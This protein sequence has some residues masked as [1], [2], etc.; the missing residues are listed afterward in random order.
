MKVGELFVALGFDIKGREGLL[1]VE[2]GMK[3]AAAG[4]GKLTLG[5]AAVNAGM[6]ILIGTALRAGVALKNFG[7]Q[8]RLDTTELQRWQHMAAVNDVSGERLTDTI[9]GLQDARAQFALGEPE[10]VGAWSLLGVNPTQ[11]P[12]KVLADLRTRLRSFSDVGIARNLASRVGISADIFQ[13]L[14]ASNEEFERWNRNLAVLPAQTERLRRLDAAWKSLRFAL[15]AV[16]NQFAA[17]FAPVLTVVAKGLEKLAEWLAIITRWLTGTSPIARVAAWAIGIMAVALLGLGVALAVV[18]AALGLLLGL[19]T[20]FSPALI[21][22]GLALAP[23]AIDFLVIAGAVTALILLLDDL[24]TA[25]KGGK[26]YFSWGPTRAVIGALKKVNLHD[27]AGGLLDFVG[28]V[29]D[30]GI[31]GG[32]EGIAA[33]PASAAGRSEVTQNNDIRIFVNGD[34][35]PVRNARF[36]HRNL[37]EEISGAAYQ[38]PVRNW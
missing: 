3:T 12:F 22:V 17:A 4:A 19:L 8:T 14:V 27:I 1:D 7:L 37:S 24:W 34:G 28:K 15:D 25:L 20:L 6:L 21:A 18:T 30:P 2:S 9:E 35:D 16:R 36:I 32:A 26:S 13:M 29:G 33:G 38:M 5:V 10:A 11:D 31:P 23:I